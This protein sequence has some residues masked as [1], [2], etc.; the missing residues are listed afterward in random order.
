MLKYLVGAVAL[1]A[2]TAANAG[3]TID[4]NTATGNI[5]NSHTYTG[6][7]LSVTA[8]GYSAASTQAA[9]YGK[10]L[11][12]DENGI[13]LAG[14]PS[15]Q[16]E[17]Y[18]GTDFIQLDVHSLFGLATGASFFMG[19]STNGENWAVYGSNTAGAL[20][21]QLMTGTDESLHA[22]TGWGQYNY[23][24]FVSL[25]TWNSTTHSYG[26][27]NVLL[28]GLSIAAA[29][30][31]ATWAMMLVGFGAMGFASRRRRTSIPQLA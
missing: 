14:D 17:I 12:G 11:G 2:A 4:F 28:G 3:V 8:T 7:G 15:G 5:G 29:P 21:T 6:S 20:G 22:L 13:G 9:L 1:A 16:H 10:N 27:G 26:T 30:E 25:G 19:S 23:Y 31:P 24:D 18:K